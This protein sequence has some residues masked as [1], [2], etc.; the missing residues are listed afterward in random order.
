[1]YSLTMKFILAF[2][3]KKEKKICGGYYINKYTHVLY[4]ISH[5]EDKLL[6][7]VIKCR[8]KKNW[9]KHILFSFERDIL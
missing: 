1:M 3:K 4:H 5:I 2:Q 8:I 6:E 9:Q 7:I